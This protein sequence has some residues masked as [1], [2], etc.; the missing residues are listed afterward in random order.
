MREH[1]IEGLDLGPVDVGRAAEVVYGEPLMK[2]MHGDNATIEPWRNNRRKLRVVMDSESVIP[3][4]PEVRRF[5]CGNKVRSTIKQKIEKNT[6]ELHEVKSDIKLH[7]LGAEFFK[8][9]SLFQLKRHPSDA[10]RT[11][12]DSRVEVHAVFPPPLNHIFENFMIEHAKKDIEYYTQQMQ[13]AFKNLG[14]SS[15]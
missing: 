14:F 4:A 9:R 5:V 6:E 15:K 10:K 1:N 13:L 7:V 8:V 3:L 2:T 12:F 11:T